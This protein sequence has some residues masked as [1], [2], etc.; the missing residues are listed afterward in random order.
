MKL[1]HL[2]A[3][4]RVEK[5]RRSTKRGVAHTW[6][7]LEVLINVERGLKVE[8]S[9]S[10]FKIL[11]GTVLVCRSRLESLQLAV[12]TFLDCSISIRRYHSTTIHLTRSSVE[13]ATIQH[14]LLSQ[15]LPQKHYSTCVET[16]P[17]TQQLLLNYKVGQR[18]VTRVEFYLFF[19]TKRE[20]IFISL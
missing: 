15:V 5:I 17:P 19:F 8:A 10:L 9:V 20:M 11:L 12:S 7:V 1:L 6:P 16:A 14:Y 4:F 18:P 2:E 13:P 3:W